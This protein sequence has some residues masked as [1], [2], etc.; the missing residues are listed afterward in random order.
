M[1]K[2]LYCDLV[3]SKMTFGLVVFFVNST[4]FQR[5]SYLKGPCHEIFDLWFFS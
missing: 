1:S 3:C 2:S 4:I 5:F